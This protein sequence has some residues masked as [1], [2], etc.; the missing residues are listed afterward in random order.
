[1]P[2]H[3]ALLITCWFVLADFPFSPGTV[4]KSFNSP[5]SQYTDESCQFLAVTFNP[6]NTLSPTEL[7]PGSHRH[8][9]DGVH[10]GDG[11]RGEDDVLHQQVLHRWTH[12]WRQ[13]RP[14]AALWHR[15]HSHHLDQQGMQAL[16]HCSGE[17]V[18]VRW[19]THGS[20]SRRGCAGLQECWWVNR[21]CSLP[22]MVRSL[23]RLQEN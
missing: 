20:L 13:T 11:Q 23:M 17:C 6:C 8:A 16:G 3:V 19:W 15:G 10:G 2:L 4:Q 9:D 5:N 1:M 14:G 7:P 12:A 18:C 21:S 22:S